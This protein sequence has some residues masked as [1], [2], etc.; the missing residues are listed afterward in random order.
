MTTSRRRALDKLLKNM[1]NAFQGIVL[2]IGSRT[3]GKFQKPLKQVKKWITIDISA[4]VKPDILNKVEDL[5]E[6][7]NDF[8]DF[9]LATEL[10][11][12]VKKPEKGLQECYR[13]LKTGGTFILSAP[14]LFY[15]HAD[16]QDYQRWT[17]FKWESE[18][19][20]HGFQ[21]KK[22]VITGLFF[23]VLLD[24][25]VIFYNSQSPLIKMM[26]LPSYPIMR[27]FCLLDHTWFV[28]SNQKLSNF[29]NGYFIISKK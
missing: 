4:E 3:C 18:L 19:S 1:K 5:R 7:Q 21:I 6:V 13:V 2:D 17:K 9:V 8:A 23:S 27:L 20:K 14:F 16:P 25:F 15:V 11:E 26:L 22:F 12:H 10:F 24:M 29:H 28:K